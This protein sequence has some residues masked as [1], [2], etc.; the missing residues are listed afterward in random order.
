MKALLETIF[1]LNLLLISIYL[2][3]S[4]LDFF[5][6]SNMNFSLLLIYGISS[7]I[8]IG[9]FIIKH[10]KADTDNHK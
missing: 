10:G 3:A 9:E 5:E 7:N 2:G 1:F 6:L 4:C 8:L